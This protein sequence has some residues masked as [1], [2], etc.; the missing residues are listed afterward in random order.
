MTQ[1]E[2]LSL[3][4]DIQKSNASLRSEISSTIY[5]QSKKLDQLAKEFERL[6]KSI[7]NEESQNV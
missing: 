1:Q 3:L 2:M 4:H 6:A 7:Q 5:W